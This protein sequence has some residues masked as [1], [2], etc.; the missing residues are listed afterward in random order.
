MIPRQIIFI[1][2][3]TTGTTQPVYDV[4]VSR[5]RP[6]EGVFGDAL[7]ITGSKQQYFT[8][9]N[10]P[11]INPEVF[12]VSFWMKQDPLYLAN[13][14]IVSHINEKK[15]AGWYFQFNVTKSKSISNSQ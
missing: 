4:N 8:V 9:P 13:S 5:F 2:L 10:N 11:E 15:T 7:A 14:A 1:V 12:S 3:L 6:T